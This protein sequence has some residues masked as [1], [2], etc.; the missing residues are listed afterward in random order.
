MAGAIDPAPIAPSDGL[1]DG[2]TD[3]RARLICSGCGSRQVD[4]VVTGTER[5]D[6]PDAGKLMLAARLPGILAPLE[7]AEAT[8]IRS[9]TQ[10]T[11]GSRRALKPFAIRSGCP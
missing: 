11:P 6:P 3:W 7:P 5:R 1:R 8:G 4:M 2:N 9:Q 10:A